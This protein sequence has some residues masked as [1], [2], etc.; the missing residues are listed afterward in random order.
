VSLYCASSFVSIALEARVVSR[1]YGGAGLYPRAGRDA[2]QRQR[3]PSRCPVPLIFSVVMRRREAGLPVRS[4]SSGLVRSQRPPWAGEWVIRG[5]TVGLPCSRECGA[6]CSLHG[7]STRNSRCVQVHRVFAPAVVPVVWRPAA[8]AS[9]CCLLAFL[10]SASI[11][12]MNRSLFLFLCSVSTDTQDRREMRT[13]SYCH[14][15]RVY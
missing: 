1:L 7:I 10:F 15:L 4:I 6:Q 3:G 14:A 5:G 2:Q 13:R 11:L 9:N 8:G 12:W